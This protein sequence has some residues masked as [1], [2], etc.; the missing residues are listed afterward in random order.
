LTGPGA[1]LLA[2]AVLAGSAA[3]PAAAPPA[4]P[5][6][7]ALASGMRSDKTLAVRLDPFRFFGGATPAGW[8]DPG[9]DDRAWAGP[10]PGPFAPRQP[11]LPGNAQPPSGVAL[12]DAT[13]QMPLLLR[14]RFA[15]PEA[16]RVRVLELSVAYND[17]FV[18][19]VNGREV[20]RRGISA[21]APPHA[22]A[23]P[24]GPEF[25]HVYIP[26]PSP[27]VPSLAAEG[28][29]L[30]V[31]IYPSSGRNTVVPTSPA[32]RVGLAAASGV[33]MCAAPIWRRPRR[34]AT[35]RA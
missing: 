14:A 21:A 1:V 7:P 2:L 28:N 30:A 13:P 26:V 27:A 19:Y 16:A 9:F 15:L 12:F 34:R 8:T 22:A 4:T 6:A 29:L 10:A 18:A 20:A 17:G 33:R 23:T 3:P 11:P 32:A 35:R 25:E 5:P 31:A 24:H